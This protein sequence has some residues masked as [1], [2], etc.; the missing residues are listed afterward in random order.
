[1]SLVPG[2]LVLFWSL[3]E[4]QCVGVFEVLESLV[5]RLLVVQVSLLAAHYK[6][7]DL[8]QQQKKVKQHFTGLYIFAGSQKSSI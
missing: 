8:G 3:P 7:D 5:P 4:P 2:F 1:M 6:I